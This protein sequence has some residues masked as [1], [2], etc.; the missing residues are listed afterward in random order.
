M[1][2][3]HTWANA[4]P[5]TRRERDILRIT[6]NPA[7]FKRM[8]DLLE[9]ATK[10]TDSISRYDEEK[11]KTIEEIVSFVSCRIS[12]D[13]PGREA[14]LEELIRMQ[15]R[16]EERLLSGEGVSRDPSVQGG[17]RV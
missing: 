15:E 12:D 17:R 16:Y 14:L 13:M 8:K 11:F 3:K 10:V 5:K 2:K 6:K 7:E 1:K 9:T 4:I